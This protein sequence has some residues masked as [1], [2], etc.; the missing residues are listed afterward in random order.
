MGE[1]FRDGKAL[2]LFL[3][4]V[5]PDRRCCAK[6]FLDIAGLDDLFGS[7]SVM[8][9][10]TGVEVRLQ[11]EAN[12]RIVRFHLA[13]SLANLVHFVRLSRQFLDVMA[14][15]VCNH[16]GLR[17]VAG[18]TQLPI[19]LRKERSVQIHFFVGGAIERT[20]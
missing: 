2:A 3:Q 10:H 13:T 12:R 9:H 19:Q 8:Q 16:V 6:C 20:G 11:F 5:V 1:G 15:F 4:S 17:K 14:D 7:L 18:G